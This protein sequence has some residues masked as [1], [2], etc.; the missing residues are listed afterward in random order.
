M[1]SRSYSDVALGD[2]GLA[3][4]TDAFDCNQHIVVA[5][6]DPAR[7][8]V[9]AGLLLR[10]AEFV[11]RVLATALR[12]SFQQVGGFNGEAIADGDLAV[13]LQPFRGPLRI[14]VLDLI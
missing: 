4:K 7:N 10:E 9:I 6:Q 11:D 8:P 14:I 3:L 2:E 5:P 13:V 1:S 12:R